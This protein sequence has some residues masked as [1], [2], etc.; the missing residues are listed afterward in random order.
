MIYLCAVEDCYKTI[1]SCTSYHGWSS[2]YTLLGILRAPRH[3]RDFLW[4]SSLYEGGDMGEGVVKIIRPMSSNGIRDGWSKNLIQNY[5]K[6]DAI[7]KII[8]SFG[9]AITKAVRTYEEGVMTKDFI[10]YGSKASIRNVI[11]S[12]QVLSCLF[13]KDTTTN[14]TLLGAMILQVNTW[15]F[16]IIT[17]TECRDY[18][19]DIN[20]Y[21]YFIIELSDKEYQILDRTAKHV[22]GHNIVLWKTGLA[23]PCYWRDKQDKYYCFITDDGYTLDG[24]YNWTIIT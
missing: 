12:Q 13:Y 11:A 3:Y 7:T 21:T 16:C 22:L 2:T 23:L 14:C 18:I 10:R 19:D 1:T 4:I 8:N 17:I 5:Y 15:Y 20:G 9:N 6:R 24:K